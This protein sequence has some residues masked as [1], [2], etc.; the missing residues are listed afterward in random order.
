MNSEISVTE[1]N[2]ANELQQEGKLDEAISAYRRASE[3][4]PDADWIH[5][6]LVNILQQRTQSD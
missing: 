1:V 2:K 6:A 3:W 4:N 5:Y